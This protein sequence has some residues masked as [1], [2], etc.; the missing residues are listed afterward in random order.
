MSL[1][2]DIAAS[3]PEAAQKF[4]ATEMQRW[5]RVVKDNNIKAD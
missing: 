5:E 4:I 3:S 1:G 2:M